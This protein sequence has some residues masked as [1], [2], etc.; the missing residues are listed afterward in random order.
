MRYRTKLF[1]FVILAISV[2]DVLLFWMMYAQAHRSLFAQIQSK[3]LSVAASAASQVNGDMLAAIS[4]PEDEGSEAY[5][6]IR[7]KLRAIRDAN[8]RGDVHVEYIY[9]MSYSRTE[10]GKV[11]FGVDAAEEPSHPG[12]VYEGSFGTKFEVA[13][14]YLVEDTPSKDEWGVWISG[15]APVK[16][17][18]GNV[19]AMLGVDLQFADVYRK[20]TTELVKWGLLSLAISMVIGAAIAAALARRVARPIAMLHATVKSIGTGEL[21]TRADT[22]YTDEFGE[23]ARAVNEM[24]EGLKQREMLKGVFAKYVSSQVLEKVLEDESQISITGER[25]KVTVLFS[26]IRGFTSLSETLRPED[27]VALLNEYFE[28]MVEVVFKHGGMLDK[29]MGDGVMAVFG[30]PKEDLYQEENAVKAA[31]EMKE[32]LARLC[33][34]WRTENKATINIGIGINTGLAV[35]GNVGSMQHMEYTAIG[36]TV[37]LASRVEQLTKELGRDILVTEYTHVALKG[38]VESERMDRVAVRGKSD[39]VTVYNVTGLKQQGG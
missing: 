16:D 13:D 14:R 10:P 4:G 23:L 9:T 26:D 1:L 30:A 24:A 36:D 12:D 28:R 11:V 39:P 27:V 22:S 25:R 8:R 3:A 32:E 21:D 35:V 20:T 29:F 38:V 2:S 31:L 18:S 33:R 7:D 5:L 19:V 15:Y 17:R 6:S 34:K 37:N